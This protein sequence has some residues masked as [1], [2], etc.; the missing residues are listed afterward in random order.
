[1]NTR[2]QLVPCLLL[3][4]GLSLV[5]CGGLGHDEDCQDDP[6]ARHHAENPA[7]GEC[8]EFFSSCNV[9]A[10]WADCEPIGPTPDAAILP[11]GPPEADGGVHPDAAPHAVCYSTVDCTTGELCPAEFGY[12][13]VPGPAPDPVPDPLIPPAC[14]SVCQTACYGDFDC[15]EGTRCNLPDLAPA[16]PIPHFKRDDAPSAEALIACAGWCVPI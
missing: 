2:T 16:C 3:G 8:W 6:S 13:G 5:A 4:L 9:P 11:D 12:C 7:T 14:M 1:M 10:S 15:A